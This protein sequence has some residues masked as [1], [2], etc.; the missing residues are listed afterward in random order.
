[1]ATEKII[2]ILDQAEAMKF[3]GLVNFHFY[4]EPLLDKRNTVFALEARSRNMLPYMHTNGD[5]LRNNSALCDTVSELY[6]Y[7]V[8]G[9]YDYQSVE[10]LDS[11]KDFWRE[12]LSNAQLRFSTVGDG[13]AGSAPSMGIP[14]ARVP[15]DRRFKIPDLVFGNAPCS[16][17]LIRLLLRYDGEMCMCCEDMQ[18]EFELGNVHDLTLEELWFSEKHIQVAND[19]LAGQREK[20]ALCRICPLAPSGPSTNGKRIELK[21]R[22]YTC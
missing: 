19:L 4:S 16:R 18:G 9:I 8:I 22:N 15:T 21:K 6:E 12:N 14:R 17:P 11:E 5:V 2:D 10:E 7:I 20:Y 13:E 3:T 1:M